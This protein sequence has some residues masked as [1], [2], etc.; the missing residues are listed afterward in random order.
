MLSTAPSSDDM[1]GMLSLSIEARTG[2]PPERQSNV[3][4]SEAEVVVE[5]PLDFYSD[6]DN[7]NG[8]AGNEKKDGG[9]KDQ[10][11]EQWDPPSSA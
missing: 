9:E 6:D 11:F 4:A 10:G 5:W 8:E 2:R 3:L 1:P 7:K